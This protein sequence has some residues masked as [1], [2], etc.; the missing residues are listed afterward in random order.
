MR[1]FS[2]SDIILKID[3]I[4]FFNSNFL[5]CV[6]TCLLWNA[7]NKDLVLFWRLLPPF[8]LKI[9]CSS[10]ISAYEDTCT[11]LDISLPG[12]QAAT[13]AFSLVVDSSGQRIS[14][15]L[16]PLFYHSHLSEVA[17]VDACYLFFIVVVVFLPSFT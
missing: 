10:E 8:H 6:Y 1:F 5:N 2:L 12:S 15:D 16:V 13:W 9:N 7:V 4:W 3:S 17:K 14:S 11:A